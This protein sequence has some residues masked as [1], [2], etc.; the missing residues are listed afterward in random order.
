MVEKLLRK[1]IGPAI[2]ALRWEIV[3]IL[4]QCVHG[5][6]ESLILSCPTSIKWYIKAHFISYYSFDVLG[7]SLLDKLMIKERNLC[8]K[9]VS[10]LFSCYLFMVLCILYFFSTAVKKCKLEKGFHQSISFSS[11]L[12]VTVSCWFSAIHMWGVTLPIS[13]KSYAPRKTQKSANLGRWD[14]IHILKY[15][16]KMFDC[17][18][19]FSCKQCPCVGKV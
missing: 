17:V 19:C 12:P 15:I 7:G 6:E 2:T 5:K 9:E 3:I 18:F 10:F 4:L 13:W 14:L 1:V 8:R 11:W 16:H